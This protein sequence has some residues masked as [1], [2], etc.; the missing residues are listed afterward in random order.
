MTTTRDVPHFPQVVHYVFK[1]W[2]PMRV[3]IVGPLLLLLPLCL[4]ALLAPH[5]GQYPA[6]A[7]SFAVYYTTLTASIVVYRLSP[8]HPL[9][10]YPGPVLAKV[11]RCWFAHVALKGK[12]HLVLVELHNRYGDIVRIGESSKLP[13]FAPYSPDSRSE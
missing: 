5:Y 1:R 7:L 3:R 10:K 12:Q 11:S 4:S 6:V 2:E 9:A 13:S 8:F